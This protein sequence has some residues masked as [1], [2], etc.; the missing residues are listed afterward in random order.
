MK[1][2]TGEGSHRSSDSTSTEQIVAKPVPAQK[3]AANDAG[4]FISATHKRERTPLIGDTESTY[5]F[6]TSDKKVHAS[7]GWVFGSDSKRCDFLLARHNRTG[8]SGKHFSIEVDPKARVWMLRNWS[9]FG[10]MVPSSTQQPKVMEVMVLGPLTQVRVGPMQI[11]IRIP[12]REKVQQQEY[13]KFL[14][15]FLVAID[16]DGAPEFQSFG[17]RSAMETPETIRGEKSDYFL[18]GALGAGNFGK[19][20]LAY[21]PT[22]ARSAEF[23]AVKEFFADTELEMAKAGFEI[24]VLTKLSHVSLTEASMRLK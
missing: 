20:S 8:I 21:A 4:M 11:S 1:D 16:D 10:T 6:R 7:C 24:R 2:E 22:K 19:V 18:C 14:D 9:A 12:R 3:P 17:F 15:S 5:V 13:D 23:F